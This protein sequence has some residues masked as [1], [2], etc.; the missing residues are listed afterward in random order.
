MASVIFLVFYSKWL[1]FS[2]ILITLFLQTSYVKVKLMNCLMNGLGGLQSVEI[3][4][5]NIFSHKY[6]KEYPNRLPRLVEDRCSETLGIS[7]RKRGK[8][9]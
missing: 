5:L 9:C 6:S 7:M 8:T 4:F 2:F 3:M 1:A